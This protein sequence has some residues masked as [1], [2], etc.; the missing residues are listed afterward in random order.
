MSD[1]RRWYTFL[2]LRRCMAPCRTVVAVV[3]VAGR[4]VVVSGDVLQRLG[5]QL[6]TCTKWK[7]CGQ[8]PFLS[9]RQDDGA[10]M[11]ARGRLWGANCG[12][13]CGCGCG[14]GVAV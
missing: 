7:W 12:Y 11:S 14:V 2:E 8:S 3:A 5:A 13:G 10:G 4:P 9:W 6:A 1:G